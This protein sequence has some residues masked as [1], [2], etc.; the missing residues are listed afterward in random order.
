MSD[1]IIKS[2]EKDLGG[3]LIH[4]S[5]PTAK[6]RQLGPF[7]FL[8]HIGP[9]SIDEQHA[10]D[11]R[12][13][14]HIGLATVTYFFSGRGFHRDSIG[15]EQLITPGDLNWMTA[16]RGIVH[17]E[18]T[19]QEDRHASAQVN[20]HGVQ[21]WV[22]LPK[23]KEECDP[24]FTHYPK[25]ILPNLQIVD[26]LKVKLMIGEYGS[27]KSPVTCASRTLF[28]DILSEKNLKTKLSF[29][30]VEVG[31]FLVA[32][33]AV[34]NDQ[35][36]IVDDLMV[37]TDPSNAEIQFEKGTRFVVIGGD[38]FLEE[39]FMWWNFVSSSKERL[40]KAALDWQ[41]QKFGQVP[42][43]AEWIPLPEGPLP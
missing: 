17:S 27:V 30:E 28:M 18:R 12:P 42:G 5:L 2:K 39:R 9:V 21:I 22:G 14:P 31:L 20:M 4:R 35:E 40:R 23:D 38:P 32:G 15:S 34:V 43:E 13:H 41:A 7:V 10:M 33:K 8:D 3:F 16:G 36:M 6:K 25:E 29:N 26:G 1:Y 37:L 24:Y 11:V 19:P